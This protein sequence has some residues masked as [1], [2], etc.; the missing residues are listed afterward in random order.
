MPRALTLQRTVVPAGERKKFLAKAMARHVYYTG[1]KCKH[2]VF[3]EADL[4]G[5]FIEFIEAPDG[6]ALAQ[7]LAGA[8]D[9]VLD[10]AR[11]YQ[12]AEL[13]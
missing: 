4:P 10:R 13:G 8:P 12:E 9:P 7:A 11:I 6:E 5:A 3:E 1:A 2:W